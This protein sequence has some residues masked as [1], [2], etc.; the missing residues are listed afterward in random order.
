MRAKDL[1]RQILTFS[2]P[3]EETGRR[4]L[5]ISLIVKEVLKLFRASLPATIEIKQNLEKGRVLADAT[6]IHQ[7]LMNLCVNATHAMDDNGVLEVNLYRIDLSGIDLE[8]LSL[9]GLKPGPFLRLSV[10]D[11][12]CG[13][14]AATMQRIFEPYFTTKD[15]GKGTGLGL[16]VVHGIVKRHEGAISVKSVP[17]RGSAFTIYLPRLKA[18]VE[19]IDGP[20]HDL[21]KGNENILFIDDEQIMM[22][23]GTQILSRLGYQVT[24]VMDSSKALELFRADADHFD[25]IITDCTMSKPTGTELAKEIRRIRPGIP[26]IICTSYSEK[27]AKNTAVDFHVEIIVKPFVAKD[28]ANMVRRTLDKGRSKQNSRPRD[29]VPG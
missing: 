5:E 2:R 8:S 15:F 20:V 22:E 4:P 29:P 7:V 10:S 9:I 27:A 21:E 1:V 16:A 23:I 18:A 24:S 28:L 17:G 12:G 25:L 11:T 26:I 19:T 13:M 6:Q 3:D 14:D